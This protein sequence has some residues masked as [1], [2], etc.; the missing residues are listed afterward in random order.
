MNQVLHTIYAVLG[1]PMARGLKG[2]PGVTQSWF[3]HPWYFHTPLVILQVA[4]VQ[5]S[6]CF[7]PYGVNFPLMEK[8]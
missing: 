2:F 1:C 7:P 5:A 8:R 4:A 3:A 6:G